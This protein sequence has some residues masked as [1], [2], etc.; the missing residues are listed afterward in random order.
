MKAGSTKAKDYNEILD[1]VHLRFPLVQNLNVVDH[2]VLYVAKSQ[3]ASITREMVILT[4]NNSA[5][6]RQGLD[7]QGSALTETRRRQQGRDQQE[8]AG[9]RAAG[10][11]RGETSRRHTL[12][13]VTI[14]ST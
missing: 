1:L 6:Y 9:K 13:E 2:P 4:V 7:L 14:M 12:A 5:A 11:S 8:T 10:D 3:R